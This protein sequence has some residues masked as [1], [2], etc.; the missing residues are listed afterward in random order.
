MKPQRPGQEDK[1][2]RLF[3]TELKGL[4]DPKHPLAVLESKLNWERFEVQFGK[5]FSDKVGRPAIATRTMV[6]LHYLKYTYDLSD[7]EVVM[8]WVENPYW[9]YFCGEK[10]FQYELPIHPTSMTRWRKKVG[11]DGAESL[12]KETIELAK[13]LKVVRE[14]EFKKV[15]VD[16]TVQEKAVTYPT[17]SKLYNKMRVK[18]VVLAKANA[19]E[20]RQS[21]TRV[22]RKALCMS[23]RYFAAR[24]PKRGKKEVRRLKTYLRRVVSDITRK[25]ADNAELKVIFKDSLDLANRLLKQQPQDKNKIYSLH[26]PEVECIAKGKAHKKYEF[27]NK[28]SV[29]AT[30]KSG[31]VVGIKALHGNPYD[32]HTLNDTI[33]QAE[34]LIGEKRIEDIFV[35]RGYRGHDYDGNA[36][37]YISGK[38]GLTLSMNRWL[39]RRWAIESKISN[40]KL[41][42]RMDRNFLLGKAGDA[43]NA[44]L[45][46]A[47][48]NFRMILTA[49]I[50]L[51]SNFWSF[52]KL[53]FS[54]LLGLVR[55]LLSFTPCHV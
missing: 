5:S 12:L 27:G 2:S 9:Q 13:D 3:D 32:G 34:R 21:Y 11:V 15:T 25:I 31:L 35:D 52:L 8:R 36:K 55:F 1:Q 4:I 23:S 26:A 24:Q 28:V 42:S 10:Y 18:L 50:R 46:G 40:L 53:E 30:S 19:V 7:E 49:V 44:L 54:D 43:I 39:K 6:G 51:L 37:V 41:N 14:S 22:G 20:L 29:A 48:V 33:N 38:K 47:A 45:C 17:D 16:T